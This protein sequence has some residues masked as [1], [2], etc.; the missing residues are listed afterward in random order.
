MHV[1][2]CKHTFRIIVKM[3]AT[4]LGEYFSVANVEVY[5]MISKTCEVQKD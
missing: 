1:S 5:K 3:M 2:K 4:F